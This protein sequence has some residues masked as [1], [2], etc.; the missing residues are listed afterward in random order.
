MGLNPF[1]NRGLLKRGT[2]ARATIVWVDPHT[3]R[4]DHDSVARY[5]IKMRLR[6]EAEGLEPYETEDQWMVRDRLLDGEGQSIP[7]RIAPE[8]RDA[9]AIDWDTLESERSARIEAATE[10]APGW[11]R[12]LSR[13]P[14]VEVDT[15]PEPG[16]SVAGDTAAAKG[17]RLRRLN[18]L[19]ESGAITADEYEQ[20]ARDA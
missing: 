19:R 3:W 13:M 17:D 5:N 8:D 10:G 2:A 1:K 20:L 16:G 18:D 9:V 6:I 11:A 15:S 4:Q 7:V 12:L 14:G